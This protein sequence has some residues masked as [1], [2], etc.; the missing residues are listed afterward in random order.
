LLDVGGGET[1]PHAAAPP[2][3]FTDAEIGAGD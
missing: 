1:W 3:L 2:P